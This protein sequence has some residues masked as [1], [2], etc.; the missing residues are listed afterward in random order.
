M[1]III[2]ENKEEG[3][4]KAYELI[5]KALNEG[6]KVFGLATGSTPEI[7]YEKLVE[8]DIDFSEAVSVNLD[9]YVG[10]SGDHEQSY[11]YF[12]QKHLF[13]KKPFKASYVPNGL[14]DEETE[15]ARYEKILAENPVDLQILGIGQNGHIA[16]NEPGT[17]FDSI[18]HKVELTDSTIQANKRF[19]EKEEDVPRYA[20]SMGLSSIMNAKKI[21]LLAFGEEKAQAVKDLV[22]AEVATE[23]IPSTILI[24]HPDVTIIVDEAAAQLIK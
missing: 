12:M 20:Y 17:S 1:E 14:N 19:F 13:D 23:D 24:N 22:T 3:S 16:F 15:V 11:R 2:V 21:I 9:E 4:I 7:M 5:H 10:L 18:T 8:S 6:A